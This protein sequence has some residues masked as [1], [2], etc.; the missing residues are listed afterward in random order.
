MEE[1]ELQRNGSDQVEIIYLSDK[2]E[3]T[4][5]SKRQRLLEIA[6]G[7]YVVFVDDDDYVAYW[8]IES[9]LDAIKSKPDVVTFYLNYTTD[10]KDFKTC[11]FGMFDKDWNHPEWFQRMPNH[12]CPVR[13]EIALK[14]GYSPISFG[15]DADYAIRLRPHLKTSVHIDDYLYIYYD[16]PKKA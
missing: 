6:K 1:L 8:Y 10:M 11:Q 7:E 3:L 14:V 9:I 5:G 2:G 4:T 12:L 13:R 16:R 15:E